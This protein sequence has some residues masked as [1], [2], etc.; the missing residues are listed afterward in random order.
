MSVRGA[1]VRRSRSKG[2]SPGDLHS[3]GLGVGVQLLAKGLV[4]DEAYVSRR[5]WEYAILD[6]CPFHPAGGCGVGPHGSYPRVWPAGCRIPRFWCPL[7]GAS[8][9]LLPESLAAGITGSLDAI[10]DAAD[11][12]ETH[13]LA[14]AV[15]V[16]LPGDAAGAVGL[17][18]AMRWLRRR[19][20]WV[21]SILLALVTLLADRF[22]G[23]A[24]TLVA[25][26]TAL[27][28]DRVL[29]AL[30]TLAAPH[31]SALA[32]PFGLRPRA[33]T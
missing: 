16:V 15:E 4:A 26:R 21:R 2:L 30:R 7:A 6:E 31:L 10:E 32:H 20:R 9:S 27:G 18:S 13:G 23:V 1:V 22:A 14:G 5:A 24:P 33:S 3:L 28:V 8:I 25:V 11:A 29:V 12:V 19:A 17:V